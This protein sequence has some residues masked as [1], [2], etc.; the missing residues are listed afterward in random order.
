MA[1]LEVNMKLRHK[2]QEKLADRFSFI[3]YPD[4]RPAD[5]RTR[6]ASRQP[7]VQFEHAM[8]LGKRMDLALLSLGLL[9]LALA[10]V[11]VTVFFFWV[12]L[13]G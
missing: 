5:A 9:A 10:A 6:A 1:I 13:G 2:L 4:L 3:Q 12:I 8:P 11:G 7:V